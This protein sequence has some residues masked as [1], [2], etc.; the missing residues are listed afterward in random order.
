MIQ[1][2]DYALSPREG[3]LPVLPLVLELY[4]RQPAR[5]PTAL[6][7][8]EREDG[9]RWTFGLAETAGPTGL[10]SAPIDSEG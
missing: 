5:R 4:R 6:H 3:R 10:V 1:L 9:W 7:V 2:S 8:E